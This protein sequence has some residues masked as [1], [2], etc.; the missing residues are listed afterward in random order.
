MRPEAVHT[1]L[2]LPPDISPGPSGRRY[3]ARLARQIA[4]ARKVGQVWMVP[5][6][7]WLRFRS[8]P[9]APANDQG[10]APTDDELR[11]LIARYA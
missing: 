3:F 2:A 11:A 6:D 4:E 9:K 8:P 1:S 7:A 5:V 10:M